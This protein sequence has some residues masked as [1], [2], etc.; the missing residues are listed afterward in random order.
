[1]PVHACKIELRI[2]TPRFRGHTKPAYSLGVIRRYTE[3]IRI[4]APK[5][6]LRLYVSL[7]CCQP[8]ELSGLLIVQLFAAAT[9]VYEP[10]IVL[11]IWL[12]YSFLLNERTRLI[13]SVIRPGVR[14][15]FTEWCMR[16]A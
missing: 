11:G 10:V 2:R 6:T 13:W 9:C 15:G 8:E 1:M 14:H 3:A 16:I 7:I 4:Q 12:C 5:T